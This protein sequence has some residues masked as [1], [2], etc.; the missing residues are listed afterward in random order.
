MADL[1][2]FYDDLIENPFSIFMVMPDGQILSKKDIYSVADQDEGTF[3]FNE[4]DF[5][6]GSF[7]P[8]HA[9][10]RLI[11]DRHPNNKKAYEFSICRWGKPPV[12]FEELVERLRQFEFYAPVLVTNSSRFIEKCGVLLNLRIQHITFHVGIDTILRLEGDLGVTGISGLPAHFIVYDRDLGKGVESYPPPNWKILPNNVTRTHRVTPPELI[13]ISSTK[14]R[15][16]K[17]NT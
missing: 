7:N 14:I 10:H 13:A 16:E 12:T 4:M 8:L 17:N 1:K 2:K 9:G 6:P 3:T 5:V 15:E 11:F